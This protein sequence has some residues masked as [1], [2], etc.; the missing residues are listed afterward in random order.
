MERATER[1]QI[2]YCSLPRRPDAVH[3]AS[4]PMPFCFI[5]SRLAYACV[6][7]ARATSH[8]APT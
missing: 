3:A 1:E 6:A 8:Q 4:G 2:A 7:L 5:R